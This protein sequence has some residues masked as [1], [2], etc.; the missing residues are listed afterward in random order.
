MNKVTRLLEEGAPVNWKDG[1]GWTTLH[2]ACFHN[3]PACVKV[4]LQHGADVTA[5]TDDGGNTPLHWAC[6]SGSID[7][8]K[9][10]MA[11]CQCDLG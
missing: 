9:L 6:L 7:C 5:R 2:W 11:T 1:G 8:V 4:L 10:L 3:H